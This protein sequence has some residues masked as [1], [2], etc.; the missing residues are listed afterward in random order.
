MIH[1]WQID[2]VGGI[3][4]AAALSV[5]LV[6]FISLIGLPQDRLTPRR[7]RILSAL[8][9]TAATLTILALWRPTL[10]RTETRPQSSKLIVLAD[11][12]RSM[13]VPDAFGGKTRWEA[14]RQT[15]SE[16][17]PALEKLR[18]EN[19]DVQ[20]YTFD[21]D[22]HPLE[23]TSEAL[24]LPTVP[25][26]RQ[27][28]IG[29]A[30]D[31]VLRSEAGNRLLGVVLLTDGAQRAYAPRDVAPQTPARRLADLGFPLY[32]CAFGQARGQ[33]QARD[34][35]IKDLVVNQTV[36]V[37]NQLSVLADARIDGLVN[38]DVPVQLLFESPGGKMQIIGTKDLHASQDG[39]SL[40]IAFDYS[41][42][43]PGEYKLTV[44]AEPQPGEIVT[45]NNQLSTFVTVLRGGLNVLYLEGALRVESTF[46][47]RSLDASADIKVKY[48]RL[49]ERDPRR[50]TL[51]LKPLLARGKYD[52]YILGDVDSSSFTP[53]ELAMLAQS[54]RQGAGLLMLGGFHSFGPGGYF[55]TPLA[56][57]LPIEM[58]SLERQNY[59][60]P[61]RSDLHL[62][63]PL[64][65]IPNARS[66][67]HHFVMELAPGDANLS[68]W[69]R[70]PPLEGANNLGRDKLKRAAQVLAETPE[71]KP[72]LISQ[73]AGGRVMAFAGDSTWRWWMGGH[74]AE[75]KRF[76][77]QAV[78]WLAH[79]DQ[80]TEGSVWIRLAQRRYAPGGRVEFAVGAQAPHGEMVSDAQFQAAVIFPDGTRRP[81]H[82]ARDNDEMA[83]V[84]I[85]TT[86]AGD[87]TL[88]V[89]ASRGKTELGRAKA[90][91]LVYEQ[92]LE[93]DN[94]AADPTL[95]ASLAKMSAS[96]GGRLLAPEELPALIDELA[97]RPIEQL[98]EREVKETPWDTW[99]FFL[100]F[101]GV[102]S[103]DWY[104]RKK[105][106]LV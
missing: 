98:V 8:R 65:M 54:V 77:R 12:S 16:A 88:E 41:P 40:P 9:L 60:E 23:L 1:S 97:Q 58:N 31:E 42:E 6:L 5:V 37:K 92:D 71:G 56:D 89:T 80:Q 76:W 103:V 82:L 50:R 49:A 91:F 64:A 3:V 86:Q 63:G 29:A 106:G 22:L 85:E 26:G 90:R 62:R 100:L 84:M 36:F 94:A 83:G 102:L 72:L 57:L 105:W 96:A 101:T 68:T 45:T 48:V 93:L 59:G 14:L 73:E 27:T 99:P 81:V 43:T 95:L 34:V 87:Y 33:G 52:V 28:A 30:L 55:A 74:E 24:D 4:V 7:R 10:V 75:H 18:A 15:L 104:L 13:L 53:D 38:Q 2:P 51:D 11:Q 61:V 70:L 17:Q 39:A 35:A 19:L 47:C 67:A 69:Q 25:D 32:A 66:G 20:L 21:A 78:L 44:R 79:K 46:L